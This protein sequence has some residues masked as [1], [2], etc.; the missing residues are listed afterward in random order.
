VTFSALQ[1]HFELWDKQLLEQVLKATE[2]KV[3][4]P[5]FFAKLGL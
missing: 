5:N 3:M 4:D 1:D 2:E